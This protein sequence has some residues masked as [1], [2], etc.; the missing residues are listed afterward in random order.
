MSWQT[1]TDKQTDR[2]RDELEVFN[3]EEEQKVHGT[4]ERP[5]VDYSTSGSQVYMQ[6]LPLPQRARQCI[7]Y[8]DLNSSCAYFFVAQMW[9][10]DTPMQLGYDGGR[11]TAFTMSFLV[12]EQSSSHAEL[13][14]YILSDF[15][16]R[17][18]TIVELDNK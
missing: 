6:R 7:R 1:Y 5:K 13:S 8:A 14:S 17:L 9:K 3:P 11:P 15:R 4:L 12:A 18:Y 2:R 10:I 16:C